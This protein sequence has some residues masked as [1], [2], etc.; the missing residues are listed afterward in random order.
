MIYAHTA[1]TTTEVHAAPS[2]LFDHLDD[3]ALLGSHMEK[4]TMMMMGGRMTYEF[5][6]AK[7]RAVGSVIKMGGS[8]L[9]I[10]L[11]VEEVVTERD[12]PRRKVWETRGRPRILIIGDYRMGFEITPSGDHSNLR[13][14]IEYD[15]PPSL[16]GRRLGRAIAPTYARWCVRRMA[17]DAARLHF[18]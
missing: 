2:Q 16:I 13:V 8:I 14:F 17:N 9:G 3:Q 5:D 11:F 10:R 4:P 6:E 7:G 18:H 15:D 1:E 12:P